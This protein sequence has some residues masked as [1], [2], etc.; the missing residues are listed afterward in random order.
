MNYL[1]DP[2]DVV[3]FNRSSDELELFWLFTVCVA[4]KTATTQARLLNKMLIGMD[5]ESPFEKIQKAVDEGSLLE[6]IIESRLGQF[7]RLNRIFESSL[8]LDLPTCTIE[9]LEAIH[10][11]GP[12]TARMFLMFTR[13]DQELAALDTH[14]LKFLNS[15]GVVAPK[16]TP[17]AGPKYRALELEFVRLAKEAKMSIAD[18]DLSIWKQYS[19]KSA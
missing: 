11:V 13:P 4:G 5:G 19:R 15:Q 12:K 1:V 16:S 10:G 7:N 9:D 2:S 18:F 17:P 3:S 8:S 6:K 14:I